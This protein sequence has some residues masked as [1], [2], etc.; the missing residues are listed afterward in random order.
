MRV[1]TPCRTSSSAVRAARSAR[2]SSLDRRCARNV[3]RRACSSSSSAYNDRETQISYVCWVDD[4]ACKTC[5]GCVRRCMGEIGWMRVQNQ[6]CRCMGHV[7]GMHA[8]AWATR[9]D[10]SRCMANINRKG[11]CA[12]NVSRRACSS[13]S[14]AFDNRGT[15]MID[16]CWM[17]AH[18]WEPRTATSYAEA[19]D[20]CAGCIQMYGGNA[21]ETHACRRECKRMGRRQTRGRHA[22]EVRGECESPTCNLHNVLLCKPQCDLNRQPSTQSTRLAC[23]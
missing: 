20:M 9:I 7:A 4:D 2:P 18:A 19:W 21:Q 1:T 10:A 3:S 13:S 11:R 14:S 15:Q 17:H 6:Q 5:T 23:M 12:R 16:I 22:R 8:D